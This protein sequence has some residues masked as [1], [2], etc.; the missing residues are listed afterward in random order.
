MLRPIVV[1]GYG[2]FLGRE[3][4]RQLLRRGE[5]VIGLARTDHAA[6]F[7]TENASRLQTMRVDLAD[8]PATAAAF[9]SLEPIG[10]IIHTA[11]VAGV[12]GPRSV[13]Q[14]ANVDAT[15]NIIAAC[16][17]HQI[18]RL[19]HTSSPSVTFGGEH[20]SGVDESVPYPDRHL[21]HYSE[22]KAIAER[23][24]L[25]FDAS[26]RTRAVALRPHLVWGN[27]DPHLIPRVIDRAR[28]GRLR[29]VGDGTNRIDTI[30][31]T[32]AASAHI[33]ALDALSDHPDRCGGRAYFLSADQPVIAWQWIRELCAIHDVSPPTRRVS[34]RT[35]H[36]I[37]AMLETVY[38][39]L[40]VR[41]EPPMTRFVA[42]QLAKDHYFDITA[43]KER[44][45]YQV[46]TSIE[47]GMEQLRD[48]FTSAE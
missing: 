39:G 42:A 7:A 3:V 20:Q 26:S 29:I 25:D 38:G 36:A 10:A 19:V 47:D 1:T 35:A 13:Y 45:G 14:R 21:C 15:R 43:A 22:T 9:A 41:R 46:Q 37:G 24:V 40:G 2:G 11:A 30:H 4:T 17:E 33:N 31:V 18:E 23:L 12:W 27:D 34:Y 8:A 6:K 5:T 44:L 32:D 28:R 48:Q 16:R